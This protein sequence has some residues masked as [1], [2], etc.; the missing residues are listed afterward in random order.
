MGAQGPSTAPSVTPVL[1]ALGL[2]PLLSSLAYSLSCSAPLN[3]PSPLWTRPACSRWPTTRSL[4]P[5]GQGMRPGGS[6]PGSHAPHPGLQEKGWLAAGEARMS[7]G[8]EASRSSSPWW[9]QAPYMGWGW[10]AELVCTHALL[11]QSALP[12]GPLQ[13]CGQALGI[14]VGRVGGAPVERAPGRW[15]RRISLLK[16]GDDPVVP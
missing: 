10:G 8:A 13:Q 14:H 5:G 4:L 7:A 9:P 6:V 3:S 16:Q 12:Q 15:G 11:L 2:P 1:S